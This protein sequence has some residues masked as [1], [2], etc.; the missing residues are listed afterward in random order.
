LRLA[1]CL[2]YKINLRAVRIVKMSEHK[3]K[4]PNSSRSSLAGPSAGAKQTNMSKSVPN[5]SYPRTGNDSASNGGLNGSRSRTSP[6]L[7][8]NKVRI[9]VFFRW[10]V[11]RVEVVY[12]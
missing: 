2:I 1:T 10:N 12:E 9:S 7:A 4:R 3:K 6:N 8:Q 11:C 5:V